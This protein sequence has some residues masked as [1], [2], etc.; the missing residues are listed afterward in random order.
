MSLWTQLV[1]GRAGEVVRQALAATV[2]LALVA[3]DVGAACQCLIKATPMHDRACCCSSDG[4]SAAV[5][6]ANACG[7]VCLRAASQATVGET[8]AVPDSAVSSSLLVS[9]AAAHDVL[10]VE[11]ATTVRVESPP[12]IL[13]SPHPILRI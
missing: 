9:V 12:L 8:R 13:A 1:G 6:Q 2:A 4:A 7:S 3:V 10:A 5:V 11:P